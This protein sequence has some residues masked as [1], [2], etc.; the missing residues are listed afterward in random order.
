MHGLG[1][2]AFRS[3][4]I[5]I[6]TIATATVLFACD[7][8]SAVRQLSD[9]ELAQR[10]AECID[11]KPTAPGRAQACENVQRECERRKKDLGLYICR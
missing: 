9:Y 10:Q 2:K 1:Y 7:G 4:I 11:R 6:F 5:G 3:M 8:N